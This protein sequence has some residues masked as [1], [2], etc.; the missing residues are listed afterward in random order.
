MGLGCILGCSPHR[1]TPAVAVVPSPASLALSAYFRDYLGSPWVG[2][3]SAGTSGALTATANGTA[4]PAP[5]ELSGHGFAR[6]DGVNDFIRLGIGAD[7]VTEAEFSGWVLFRYNGQ[8][9][10]N[11]ATIEAMPAILTDW[12]G[13]SGVC[14]SDKGL[15]IYRN[16]AGSSAKQANAP[17]TTGVWHLG[18]FRWDPIKHLI[19]VGVDGPPNYSYWGLNTFIGVSTAEFYLGKN[20]N[21]TMFSEVDVADVGM[22]KG[23]LTDAQFVDL[24]SYVRGTYGPIIAERSSGV[25]SGVASVPS[26]ASHVYAPVTHTTSAAYAQCD[27]AKLIHMLGRYYRLGGWHSGGLPEWNGEWST[28]EV[29]SSEDLVTWTKDLAHDSNPPTIGPGARPLRCHAFGHAVVG[30]HVYWIGS[31]QYV[32]GVPQVWKSDAPG[33]PTGWTKLPD[34][35][36]AARTGACVG[37]LGTD[38]HVIGGCP[39]YFGFYAA[40]GDHWVFDTTTEVW[41][42]MPDCPFVTS[43]ITDLPELDGK[44][45]VCGGNGG[46]ANGGERVYQNAVWAWDGLK[47]HLQNANPPWSGRM[48]VDTW[49]YDGKLWVGPGRDSDVSDTADTWVSDDAGVTWTLVAQAPWGPTHAD[50]VCVTEAD[51]IVMATGFGIGTAVLSLKV[52]G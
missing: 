37:K 51:G 50:G 6:C 24:V 48:W 38:I 36:Y 11:S 44:L 33:S 9:V 19:Q 28:N 29:W 40:I 20:R 32:I 10:A 49:V 41:T 12:N 47:W 17:C 1:G 23:T 34:A 21:G 30:E 27:G 22:S 46:G 31:D 43:F 14:F 2:S 8:P 4:S 39:Y 52:A 42:Q 5:F 3:V 7:L 18:T 25:A 13:Y 15:G 16:L 35:P 45:F 26:S